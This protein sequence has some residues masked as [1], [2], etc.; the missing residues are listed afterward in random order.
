MILI[1][2]PWRFIFT[3]FLS[4]YRKSW[5]NWAIAILRLLDKYWEPGLVLGV[6]FL[7]WSGWPQKAVLLLL[8]GKFLRHL[9]RLVI[10]PCQSLRIELI[11]L[12]EYWFTKIK[13]ALGCPR[14]TSFF[15]IIRTDNLQRESFSFLNNDLPTI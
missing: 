11:I 1:I 15:I 4:L 6:G 9:I 8:G 13:L 2:P 14:K 7:L 10:F 12:D 5:M 3:I